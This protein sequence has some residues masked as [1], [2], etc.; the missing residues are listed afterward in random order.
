MPDLDA[1][2]S[3][4][5]GC[6][7]DEFAAFCDA[8]PDR[9]V[10]VYANTSAA[11][12]ARADWMVTSSCALAIVRA[13]AR[14]R[15]RRSCGR[16][17]SIWAATSSRPDRRRHAAVERR[18]H[19]AR[20]VQGRS[21]SSC[22][23]SS[24]RA[25]WCWCIPSRPRRVVRQADVVGSTSQLLK[26][27][28]DGT[29]NEYIV[30]TDNGM[31][32]RMRQLAPGK[33]LIEAPTAGNSATCKSCAHCPWMAMN[34]LQGVVACLRTRRRRDPRAR[35]DAQPGAGLHRAHARLRRQQPA[36]HRQPRP[37]LRAARRRGLDGGAIARRAAVRVQRNA[38][39]GARSATS[40]TRC[41]RTSARGD[42][43]GGWCPPGRACSAQC[44]CARPPCCAGRDW[45]DGCHARAWTPTRASTGAT[46]KAPTWQPT[47]WSATSR[48]TRARCSPA[49]RPALNFLQLL[50]GTATATRAPCAGHRRRVAQPARLRRARHA[51][52][53]A[54]PAPGAEVRGARRRR[55]QPAAGAVARHP[56]Q[57]EPHRRCRRRRAQALQRAPAL[58]AGV[59]IQIEVETLDQLREALSARRHQRAARQLLAARRCARRWR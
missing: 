50:S 21:S 15:A 49:E 40:T 20:R 48:P 30:A 9:T 7:P 22:C 35:A 53:A 41:S 42:W 24:T 31:F 55:R 4:D 39:A 19:R 34:G 12:K 14:A 5:L 16:P 43:T 47:P 46:T 54:R 6:P 58:N 28:V 3:L 8:H 11:V 10:V 2:C 29:A 33:T 57:G 17:T 32:H 38:G 23:A 45:F 36:S 18:L 56:D 44:S 26:A 27:V 59:D 51:Q 37:R 13:P 25:R 1:T 52:D